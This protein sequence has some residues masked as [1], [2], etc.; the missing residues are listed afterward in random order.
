MDV[1]VIG[2]GSMGKNHARVYSELKN[3]DNVYVTDLNQE[4]AR[5][6]AEAN[7]TKLSTKAELLL[8]N[9]DAISICVPTE[10]HHDIAL[11][12]FEAG[13]HVLIEKPVCSTVASANFLLREAPKD[14]IVGVGHIERFNPIV[15]EIHNMINYRPA[16]IETKRHNPSSARGNHSIV[17]DLMI[18][19]IDVVFNIL[20]KPKCTSMSSSGTNDLCGALFDLDG[21]TAYMSASR[22]SSKKIRTIYIEQ[23]D[24]T[25]EG[26]YMSQEITI[27]SK[28][29]RYNIESNRYVQENVIE[30]VLVTKQEPLKQ[31]LSTFINCVKTKTPFPVTLEQATFNLEVAERI[32]RGVRV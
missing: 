11:K 24:C 28:P 6:V 1:G 8:S 19:D 23:E 2:V 9:V 27:Y 14:L 17:K 13:V 32:E 12:A 30:K 25:I 4:M 10:Y 29:G 7:G 3:V 20:D 21:T 5:K 31:E 15:N 26:D 22:K 16:Y 18:H